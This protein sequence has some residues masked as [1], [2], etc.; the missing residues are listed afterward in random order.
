MNR[1]LI[2]LLSVIIAFTLSCTATYYEVKT[3]DGKEFL[4]NEEPEF[5]SKSKSY[6]F[7][8]VKGNKWIFNR[9]EIMSMERK[10]KG[11]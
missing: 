9:E 10:I 11:H 5:N 8:D 4:T 7:T 2:I 1:M 3:K 6:E